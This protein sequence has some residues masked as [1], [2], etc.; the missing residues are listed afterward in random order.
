MRPWPAGVEVTMKTSIDRDVHR[1]RLALPRLLAFPR[2]SAGARQEVSVD[3]K[4]PMRTS[5]PR[6]SSVRLLRDPE[7]PLTGPGPYTGALGAGPAAG[8]THQQ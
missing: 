7:L 1:H 8:W 6:S 2:G 4:W 5:G 3:W